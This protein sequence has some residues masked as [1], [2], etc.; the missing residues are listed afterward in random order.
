LAMVEII[1]RRYHTF[2]D[3]LRNENVT[4]VNEP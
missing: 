2:S 4:F 3:L 1:C